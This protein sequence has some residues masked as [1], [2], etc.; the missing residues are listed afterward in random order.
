MFW[1][2]NKRNHF[3]FLISGGLPN[4]L[5]LPTG[6]EVCCCLAFTAIVCFV[7]TNNEGVFSTTPLE[8]VPGFCAVVV[9]GL[10]WAFTG[11][12]LESV[13][14]FDL[15]ILGTSFFCCL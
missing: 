2:R 12:L 14:L 11:L 7:P 3:P 4:F 5:H 15:V 9:L 13:L 10:M 8:T 6:L 1:F